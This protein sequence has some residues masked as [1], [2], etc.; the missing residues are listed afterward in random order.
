MFIAFKVKKDYR[1]IGAAYPLNIS[2]LT[3]ER[4]LWLKG[5]L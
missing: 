3:E 2:Q 5:R 1:P 4:E